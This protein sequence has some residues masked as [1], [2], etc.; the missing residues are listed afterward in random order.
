MIREPLVHFL[1]IGAALFLLFEWTG[2]GADRR[3]T[4]TRGQIDRLAESFE[5]VWL[6]PPTEAEL[7]GL[8]DDYVREEV[9]IREAVKI[10]L[11]RDDTIIRR[12]LRQKLEF[13]LEDTLDAH[14]PTDDDLAF[15]LEKN[16]DSFRTEA[17]VSFRQ[18]YVSRDHEG[19][20]PVSFARRLLEELAPA[21]AGA[22][23]E[24]LGDPLMLP[25]EVPLSGR[26]EI[27]TLF[28]EDFTEKVLALEPDRWEGPFESGYGLHLVFV[29][30]RIE[31]SVPPLDKVRDI[32]ERDLLAARRKAEL[33][34]A[35]ERM[36]SE[37]D[38]VVE[39]AP[40]P[41]P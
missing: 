2:G 1:L 3:I 34:Q 8:L 33:D 39:K 19:E 5:A 26:R 4:I 41:A 23:I 16:A 9:A 24:R 32:V 36:L 28:G 37:Y 20:D 21:G 15:W 7:K 11:D 40:V 35:Y 31:G 30:E 14:P 22:R 13:M 38:V 25:Q 10:G 17:Q 18:V 29:R 12:R 27:A 6:R